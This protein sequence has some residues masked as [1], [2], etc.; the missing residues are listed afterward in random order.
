MS[1]KLAETKALQDMN[2][3]VILRDTHR[4]ILSVSHDAGKRTDDEMRAAHSM[5][6]VLSPRVEACIAQ[7]MICHVITLMLH[8]CSRRSLIHVTMISRPGRTQVH[9]T[10]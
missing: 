6:E 9:Q 5:N 3:D 4:N 10:S 8:E 7:E 2:R 1:P